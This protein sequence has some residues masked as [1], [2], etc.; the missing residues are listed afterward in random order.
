MNSKT[1][2]AAAVA[3][4][5][6]LAVTSIILVSGGGSDNDT[7]GGEVTNAVVWLDMNDGTEPISFGGSGGD[8]RSIVEAALSGH[9]VVFRANGNISSVDGMTNDDSKVWII[10]R[11]SSPD[12]WGIFNDS[13]STYVDGM[14]IAVRYADKAVDDKGAASYS[15][16][17]I[18]VKYRVYFLIQMREELSST[19]WLRD[20]PLTDSE[21][22]RGVW[23]SGE[24]STS[25]EALADAVLTNFFPGSTYEVVSS[26]NGGQGSVKY[27]VDGEEGLFTYGT[28]PSMYG[29]FVSFMGWSDTKVGSGGDYG[30]WTFWNQYTYSPK[31]DSLDDTAY[32]GF[33][34]YSFGMYDITEYRYFGLVLKTS[35]ME[36]SYIDLP[37][38]SQILKVS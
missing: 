1:V 10:F 5:A 18:D 7:P 25:S 4:I 38:P 11:W 13:A 21:K 30:T 12:G 6:V 32:W 16:P 17:D 37:T 2:I 27:I 14:N 34:Q 24:G 29:W 36:D 8:I 33:N 31:A 3:V 9:D 26:D 35:S 23:I 15:A 19:E 22:K 28:T 20:L